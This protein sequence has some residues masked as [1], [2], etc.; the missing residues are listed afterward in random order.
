MRMYTA[1][2]MC[3]FIG[4][5]FPAGYIVKMYEK[6]C[7]LDTISLSKFTLGSLS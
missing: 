1:S 3:G 4:A 5:T 6:P 2:L 7:I